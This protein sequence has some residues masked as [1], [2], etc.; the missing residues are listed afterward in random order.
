MNNTAKSTPCIRVN[1]A[2]ASIEGCEFINNTGTSTYGSVYTFMGNLYISN[3]EFINNTAGKRGGSICYTTYDLL[4]FTVN[5]CTFYNSK[6]KQTGG[7]IY[8]S[9]GNINFNDC[10]FHNS[11]A[12]RGGA[13]LFENVFDYPFLIN[14][15]S[16]EFI[17]CSSTSRGG[18]IYCSDFHSLIGFN[19]SIV[20]AKSKY[21]AGIFISYCNSTF[22]NLTITNSSSINGAYFHQ[23]GDLKL[24]NSLLSSNTGVG[25]A[26]YLTDMR[27]VVI[28][29]N[30]FKNNNAS[31]YGSAIYI[32]SKSTQDFSKNNYENNSAKD[33]KT[34]YVNYISYDKD[35]L[36][37]ISRN[38][39][40]FIGNYADT[41]YI[42][43]YY[44]LVDLNQ[45]TSV[46]N[47]DDEGNCWAFAAIGGLES[48]VLKAHN[49]LL[50][51]SENNMKN[52]A[53]NT[54]PFGW[55][56]EPNYGRYPNTHRLPCKLARSRFRRE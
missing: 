30:T 50:D 5:N 28:E 45:T 8:I 34:V 39:T 1:K 2:D 29:N 20:N 40:F 17:N 22:D 41:D 14:I 53:S 48:N 42:P 33:N 35:N 51:L 37:I 4:N 15:T 24:I 49:L 6:A 43:P 44:N 11:Q 31:G 21:G 3:C 10:K 23:N 7:S 27:N 19:I 47:Q 16:T 13:I 25:S 38:Y 12:D 36:I 52:I 55:I 46:K 9:C 26:I 32:V 18:A 56:Y 54:S